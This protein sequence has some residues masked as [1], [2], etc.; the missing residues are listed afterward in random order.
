MTRCINGDGVRTMTIVPD[1]LIKR[2]PYARTG[3]LLIGIGYSNF[4]LIM[5]PPH[6]SQTPRTSLAVLSLKPLNKSVNSDLS[7]RSTQVLYIFFFFN[8]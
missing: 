2:D 1:K 7:L 8:K 3:V 4:T 5:Y 6:S